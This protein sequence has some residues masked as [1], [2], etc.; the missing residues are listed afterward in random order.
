MTAAFVPRRKMR[1]ATFALVALPVSLTTVPVSVPAL[2]LSELTDLTATPGAACAAGA[3]AATAIAATASAAARFPR[4]SM[5]VTPSYGR[6]PGD[7]MTAQPLRARG[8][9]QG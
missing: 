4:P 5:S 3:A 1:T 8:E 9:L 7:P 6:R 2:A